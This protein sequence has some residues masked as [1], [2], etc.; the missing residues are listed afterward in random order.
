MRPRLFLLRRGQRLHRVVELAVHRV[1]H[2]HRLRV[3]D[4][5]GLYRFGDA[6]D[7]RLLR[8][9]DDAASVL[10]FVVRHHHLV[11]RIPARVLEQQPLLSPVPVPH[12][13]HHEQRRGERRGGDVGVL[14]PERDRRARLRVRDEFVH[15]DVRDAP[16]AV[17]RVVHRGRERAV[18]AH[19]RRLRDP[20]GRTGEVRR[21]ARDARRRRGGRGEEVIVAVDARG[22]PRRRLNRPRRAR[23]AD[24]RPERGGDVPGEAR[25]ARRRASRR[26]RGAERARRAHRRV[27]DGGVGPR[28]A[29]LA[30]VG[31]AR[32]G[33]HVR[34][35]GAIG[36]H[37]GGQHGRADGQRPRGDRGVDRG[38][39]A[40]Q[41][42]RVPAAAEGD[43]E[44][45]RV[46]HVKV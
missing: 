41:L 13:T 16:A 17:H 4:V 18:R 12:V 11:E 14:H 25:G 32:R 37:R 2:R 9:H 1:D 31:P 40:R 6:E 21:R 23:G 38:R 7:V 29:Q 22:L 15:G 10:V 33:V 43:R 39:H 26:R 45:R 30:D 35:R 19:P 46:V 24:V 20:R 8:L 27:R 34:P 28:R 36:R 3:V 44:Q 5:P 42:R